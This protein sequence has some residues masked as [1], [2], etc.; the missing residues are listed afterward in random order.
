MTVTVDHALILQ[1]AEAARELARE[2]RGQVARARAATPID[3]PSLEPLEAKARWLDE[4][5][6]LLEG[7]ADLAL[8]LDTTGSGQ[9]TFSLGDLKDTLKDALGDYAGTEF[10]NLFSDETTSL[11]SLVTGLTPSICRVRDP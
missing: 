4:Q 5:I 10:G 1:S 11:I 3:L 8:V 7:L 9:A 6:P 2:L